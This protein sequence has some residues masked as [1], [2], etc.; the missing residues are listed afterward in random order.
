M[1]TG[2]GPEYGPDMGAAPGRWRHRQG[3]GEG[4]SE[5]GVSHEYQEIEVED[6]P[7]HFLRCRT[8]SIKWRELQKAGNDLVDDRRLDPQPQKESMVEH[9]RT[10]YGHLNIA[11]ST[12]RQCFRN[13]SLKQGCGNNTVCQ[14]HNAWMKYMRWCPGNVRLT[15]GGCRARGRLLCET[16]T[17]VSRRAVTGKIN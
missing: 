5:K 13:V 4:E 10:N 16:F 6:R 1:T 9:G 11:L 14:C 17:A 8:T 7:R 12:T 3:V 2:A 15:W